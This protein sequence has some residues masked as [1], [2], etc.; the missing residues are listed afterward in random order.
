MRLEKDRRWTMDR[1]GRL[2]R[3]LEKE[4]TT[5]RMRLKKMVT[6]PRASMND[7]L[8][9]RSIHGT[10][11]A[12]LEQAQQELL[13]DEQ[14]RAYVLVASQAKAL[15]EAWESLHRGVYGI[16][17]ECGQH[18]PHRRLKAVPGTAFCVSCQEKQEKKE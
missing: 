18:I 5:T 14:L 13:R 15:D 7:V 12:Q 2:A 17:R 8:H 10:P 1:Q 4:R 9:D 3:L 6:H 11:E 16:C